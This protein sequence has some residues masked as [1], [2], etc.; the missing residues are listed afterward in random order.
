MIISREN[1]AETCENLR[2]NGK[3]IVFTNGCFDILHAGHTTYLGEAKK[4]G[5]VLVVGLNSDDSVRRLK[6]A[7][8]PVNSEN[9]RAVVLDAL[10][11]VDFVCIF[12]EDTPFELISIVQPDILVKGGDYELSTIIGADIVQ[13]RGGKVLT[14][15]LVAGK[16]TSNIIAKMIPM[17]LLLLIFSQNLF[18]ETTSSV[19]SRII[20]SETL[21]YVLRLTNGDKLTGTILEKSQNEKE[22][23]SIKFRTSIGTA[24]IDETQI[25]EITPLAYLY[26]HNHRVFLMPTAEPIGSNHFIGNFELLLLYGGFGVSD[27]LS[28]TAGRTMIPSIPSGDQAST[29]N[30][31]ATVYSEQADN[32]TAISLALGTNVAYLN[33]DHR[34]LNIYT[35][36]TFTG[37][38]SR[39]TAMLFYKAGGEDFM[40]IRAGTYGLAD[41]KYSAGAFGVGVGLD[42]KFT[43]W[44]GVHFIG[45][46]WNN[47][48]GRPT[49]S[50]LLLGFRLCNSTISADFG[51]AVFTQ[52]AFAPFTSF[53]W[54]PF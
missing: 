35:V 20:P 6:G 3:D 24:T 8:R 16:S 25:V 7:E 40:T 19:L 27:W 10:R 18:G 9:D 52:P 41:M 28:I 47:D 37:S 49:N 17:L 51:I 34:L 26:R 23:F 54:T 44:H 32:S 14:I 43:S 1:L 15:P 11:A 12:E 42:T 48:V 5:D 29:I 4:L 30:A 36:G 50:A 22:L 13:A 46:L 53:S 21:Q 31:K 2:K 45:E 38:R 39:I 33:Y